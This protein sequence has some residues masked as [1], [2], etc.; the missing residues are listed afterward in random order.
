MEFTMLMC[1]MSVPKLP[2]TA[3]KHRRSPATPDTY[4][5]PLPPPIYFTVI[6]KERQLLQAIQINHS[7]LP[8]SLIHYVYPHQSLQ[9]TAQLL[10]GRSDVHTLQRAVL[11]MSLLS[12]TATPHH[13]AAISFRQLVR[14]QP[15]LHLEHDFLPTILYTKTALAGIKLHPSPRASA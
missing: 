5:T 14:R 15:N 7:R 8:S 2:K 1:P 11:H 13:T 9:G 4:L 10:P 6:H 12:P 3:K